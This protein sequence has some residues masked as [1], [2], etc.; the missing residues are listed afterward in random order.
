MICNRQVLSAAL[1]DSMNIALVKRDSNFYTVGFTF[2]PVVDLSAYTV[3][4]P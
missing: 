2:V 3:P 1:S 4:L